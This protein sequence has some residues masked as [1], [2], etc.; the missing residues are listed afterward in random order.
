MLHPLIIVGL[1]IGIAAIVWTLIVGD[2]KT[3]VILG[4]LVIVLGVLTLV[5]PGISGGAVLAIGVPVLGICC[6]I[7]LLWKGY[8]F[9]LR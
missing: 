4:V 3:K 5:L 6:L 8:I 9:K 2:A 7:Y 1:I